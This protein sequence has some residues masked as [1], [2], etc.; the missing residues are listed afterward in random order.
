MN[1]KYLALLVPGIRRIFEQRNSLVIQVEELE[2]ER[3]R[4]IGESDG[5]KSRIDER[6]AEISGRFDGLESSL[7]DQAGQLETL[8]IFAQMQFPNWV[9]QFEMQIRDVL[10]TQL[11]SSPLPKLGWSLV[12]KREIAIDSDDHIYPWGTKNDNTRHP[13]FVCACE[14]LIGEGPIRHLDLG[15]AGGGLVWDFA[16]R[17]HHSVGVEGS[18]YSLREQRAEWRTIPDRLFTADICYPFHF[19]NLSGERVLFDVMSAWEL[20][21]HISEARLAG[22]LANITES[23][24]PHGYVIASIAT[25]HDEDSNTGA[26]YHHTVQQREWWEERFRSVG[27]IPQ[28]ALLETDD[29]VRGRGNPTNRYDWD[30][31]LNPETGFHVVLRYECVT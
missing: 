25:T 8:Y 6:L 4:L 7:K 20:F 9:S 24:R 28:A 16:L 11:I 13:R 10:N 14:T 23:L 30:S 19:E 18:D 17:G 12:A 22:L 31:R 15:S 29:F 27:L 3:V 5:L 2:A 1:F 21:E 26:V